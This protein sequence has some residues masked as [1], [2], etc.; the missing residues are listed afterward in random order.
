MGHHTNQSN[1]E[2]KK[3]QNFVLAGDPFSGWY[4][5]CLNCQ[6]TDCDLF[7][8]VRELLERTKCGVLK[9]AGSDEEELHQNSFNW[10]QPVSGTQIIIE[11]RFSQAVLKEQVISNMGEIHS[12]CF[13]HII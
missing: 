13:K 1:S 10:T 6:D 7:S 12:I 8:C 9:S 5:G 2:E 11:T 4:A 3:Y